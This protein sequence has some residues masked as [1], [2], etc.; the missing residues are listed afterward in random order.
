M[1][2]LLKEVVA[3][4]DIFFGESTTEFLVP[5]SLSGWMAYSGHEATALGELQVICPT[6]IVG[7]RQT[8]L[9]IKFP[10]HLFWITQ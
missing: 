4:I 5:H 10:E 2:T 9:L 1:H 6:A 3:G 8:I 7:T